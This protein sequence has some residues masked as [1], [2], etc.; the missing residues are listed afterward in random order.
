MAFALDVSD[1]ALLDSPPF[2]FFAK[3]ELSIQY[4]ICHFL[5]FP[6]IG[7]SQLP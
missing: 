6:L 5:L 3:H 1:P 2:L 4:T 7:A